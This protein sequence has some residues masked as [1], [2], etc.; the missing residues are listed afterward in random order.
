M[1]IRT[2]LKFRNLDLT[3]DINDRYTRLFTSGVFDG[4]LVIPVVGQLKIDL[5][6]PWKLINAEGMVVEETADRYRLDTPSGQTTVIACKAV[7]YEN[8]VPEIVVLAIEKSAYDL[9]PDQYKYIVF[10]HVEVPLGATIILSIYIKYSA[11]DTIDKLGRSSLRGVLSNASLLPVAKDNLAG[12]MWMVSDGIGGTPQIWGWDGV[13]WVI[14]TDAATAMAILATHRANLYVDEKHA[15][16][17]E[18]AALVGTSGTQPSATNKFIDNADT[19]IPTQT[20]NDALLGSDGT[21]SATNRYVTEQYPLAIPE[22][23]ELSSAPVSASIEILSSEGPVYV[24]R[25]GAGSAGVYFKH[26]DLLLNREYTTSTG[27]IVTVAGVYTDAGLAPATIIDPSINPNVDSNGFFSGASLYIKHSITPDTGLRLLYGKHGYMKSWPIDALLRRTLNDAQ[28]TADAIKTVEGIKGRDWD[29]VVPTN[30]TNIELRKDVVDLK[31]YVSSVFKADHVV[32][33]FTKVEGV[34]DFLSDFVPNVGIPQ[35]YSYENTGLVGFNYISTTATVTYNTP[36]TLVGVV[37]VGHVFMDGAGNEFQVTSVISN[38]QITIAKRNGIIPLVINNTVT[39]S[40]HGA[41]KPDNNPRKVNL[42]SLQYILGRERI[43]CREVEIVPN[44]FHPRTNNIAFQI[45][46]PLHSSYYREPRVRFYGGFQ[47][48]DSG[49]RSK[50]VATNTG[51]ILLTGFFTDVRLLVDLKNAS[52]S[53]TVKVDGDLTGTV[54]DLS[55]SN[56][57]VN[58]G[59]DD[60]I[61]QQGVEIATGLTDLQA[62]TIEILIDNSTDDFIIYGIDLIRAN[63]TTVAVLPGRAFVQSDLFKKD[64]ISTFTPPVGLTRS[65]GAVATRYINRSLVEATQLTTLGDFDGLTAGPA[66]TASSGT[67]NFTVTSGLPK[68]QNYKAGDI[69]KLITVSAE[70]VKQIQSIGPGVNQIVFSDNIANSGS[71]IL[72]HVASSVGDSSDTIQEYA[73]YN[74]TDL[75]TR[76]LTDLSVLFFSASDRL[77]TVEDGTTSIVGKNIRYVT[78]GID[79]VDTALEL[80]DATSFVRIR[81]VACQLNLITANSTSVTADF[82][83]DG[84]PIYSTVIPSGGL[85]NLVGWTNARYQTHEL[86]ISNATGMRLSGIILHE[87]THATKIEGSL[88]STQ[89]LVADHDSSTSTDGAVIPMGVIGVDT[90]TM[91]GV[92]V[93]GSGTGTGWTNTLDLNENPYWYRYVTTDLEGSYFEYVFFGSGFE[94]E[95]LAKDDRGKPRL[96]LNNVL[97]TAINFPSAVLKD[98][99]VSTGEVDMYDISSTPIRKKC[100]VTELTSGK[101]TL[102]VQVQTPRARNVSSV[103]FSINIGTIYE[104]NASKRLSYSPSKGFRGKIGVDDFAYGLNWV[105]DERNFDSG[106]ISKEEIPVSRTILLETR[107]Q[108]VLIPASSISVTIAFS[109]AFDSTDYSL[110]CTLSNTVDSV[111]VFRPVTVTNFTTGGFT[112]KW[113]DPLESSNYYLNYTA[114]KFS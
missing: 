87:P 13:Q 67:P 23:K 106:A 110:T 38:Q 25:G 114:T 6:P 18:K 95:Y 102:K 112:V 80:I 11:R 43:S 113:N 3:K 92:F 60:D 56:T 105:R 66:G 53:I 42:S 75:G 57:V 52:P 74:T 71:A 39:L 7:Y 78:T 27:A 48:R 59:T 65:R 98:V 89:N 58:L 111:A 30:E 4:G 20:E 8:D 63:V 16:D 29:V 88:I 51:I 28:T 31:E 33:D 81:A 45:R 10:A 44:E 26:Y 41:C 17:K 96:F 72:T 94:L 32:G 77:F 90:F 108:R 12:D 99:S 68:F 15:T 1:A 103:G 76:Q 79:G 82:A 46:T 64:T 104:A 85:T 93:D 2:L 62:H 97:V 37:I 61:Q 84:S 69:V 24:G 70:E 50:V 55:R 47:N 14:L 35:N 21:P 34:P 19:R 100:A 83:I 5:M 109:A 36:V 91:G 107:A 49:N 54:I 22:E 40:K 101:Y 9:L 86:T 73:R